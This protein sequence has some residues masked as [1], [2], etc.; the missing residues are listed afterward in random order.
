[1]VSQNTQRP[2]WWIVFLYGIISIIVGLVFLLYPLSALSALVFVLGVYWLITGVIGLL[3]L[4]QDRTAWG[5]K[6]FSSILGIIAGFMVISRPLWA[7]LIVPAV[8]V[9]VLA[10]WGLF[11]GI[12]ML[13]AAFKGAG[14]GTGIMGA[15][16]LFLAL[17]LLGNP[18]IAGATLPWVF[19]FF[20]I[21]GGIVHLFMAFTIKGAGHQS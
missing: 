9:I 14:W 18:I 5:W 7:T 19:G 6:L 3:D 13:V 12:I 17:T 21:F 11:M 2:T 15:L 16:T 4:F 10:V 20:S 8:Y 1:M